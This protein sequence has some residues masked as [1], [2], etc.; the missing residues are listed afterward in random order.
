MYK[1][2]REREQLKLQ[3]MK[4]CLD[5]Q[6]KKSRAL[7]RET[8]HKNIEPRRCPIL[9]Q[10]VLQRQLDRALARDHWI[11]EEGAGAESSGEASD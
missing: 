8:A 5:G 7:P 9:D 10:G 4:W 1:D 11:I 6:H 2:D 3:M